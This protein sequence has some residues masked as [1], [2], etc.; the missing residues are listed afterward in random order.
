MLKGVREKRNE[1]LKSVYLKSFDFFRGKQT[2]AKKQPSISMTSKNLNLSNKKFGEIAVSEVISSK[3]SRKL[4]IC[5]TYFRL[6]LSISLRI[7]QQITHFSL[8]EIFPKR[9]FSCMGDYDL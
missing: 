8:E 5:T 3:L 9:N 4:I 6:I 1:T 2:F 7:N